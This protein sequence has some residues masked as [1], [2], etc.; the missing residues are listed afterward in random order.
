MK[1]DSKKMNRSGRIIASVT[2]VSLLAGA[3]YEV[4]RLS[5]EPVG[6]KDCEP[7]SS[8]GE[9][10]AADN[11]QV[12]ISP[13]PSSAL[14][15]WKQKGGTI[16]DVS[17]LNRTAVYGIVQIKNVDDIKNAVTLAKE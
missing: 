17:C 2:A 1:S 9:L 10:N 5:A 14:L 16:N 12:E 11:I 8:T 3:G 6:E 4:N 15:Q 13:L 7:V